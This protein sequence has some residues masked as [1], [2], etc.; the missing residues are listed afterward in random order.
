[1]VGSLKI[2]ECLIR[3]RHNLWTM[4]NDSL[5]SSSDILGKKLRGSFFGCG[6]TCLISSTNINE[7]Q[8]VLI[9]V[10]N[11]VGFF[12]HKYITTGYI[13][14]ALPVDYTIIRSLTFEVFCRPQIRLNKADGRPSQFIKWPDI[15]VVSLIMHKSYSVY[16]FSPMI[17]GYRIAIE[18]ILWRETKKNVRSTFV[19]ISSPQ[20]NLSLNSMSLSLT[21]I[22]SS[23][24]L[25]SPI[26]PSLGYY[27]SRHLD[28]R[29]GRI[30]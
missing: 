3:F 27:M 22:I 4:A 17:F 18:F 19:V 25:L 26:S 29:V 6:K 15:W 23:R 21:I 14:K 2:E 1:M 8:I 30:F 5:R 20:A 24:S 28:W 11:S 7:W 9:C 12:L 16:P 13:S 10:E